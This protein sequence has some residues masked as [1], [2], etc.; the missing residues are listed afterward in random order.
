MEDA[1]IG[2]VMAAGLIGLVLWGAVT[3]LVAEGELARRVRV[4]VGA[5]LILII[6]A[7]VVAIAGPGGLLIAVV[8]GGVL[9]WIIMGARK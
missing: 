9:T 5:L 7:V 4:V 6:G 3:L 8:V 2:K 1:W